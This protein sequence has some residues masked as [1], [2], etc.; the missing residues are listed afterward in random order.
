MAN[1][2]SKEKRKELE[3]KYKDATDRIYDLKVMK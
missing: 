1:S 3:I 2:I